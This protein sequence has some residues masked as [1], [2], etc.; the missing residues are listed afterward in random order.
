MGQRLKVL[1]SLVANCHMAWFKFLCHTLVFWFCLDLAQFFTTGWRRLCVRLKCIN[2]CTSISHQRIKHLKT[3]CSSRTAEPCWVS[4]VITVL[5]LHTPPWLLWVF[6]F[7]SD[8]LFKLHWAVT[9]GAF[10]PSSSSHTFAA[11]SLSECW[12]KHLSIVSSSR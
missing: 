2:N 3:T 9:A 7:I 11:L 12:M 4:L 6:G 5:L 10:R 8:E 1:Q